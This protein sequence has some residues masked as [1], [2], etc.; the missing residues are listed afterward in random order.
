[1]KNAGEA[2]A[3]STKEAEDSARIAT[4]CLSSDSDSRFRSKRANVTLT[5]SD[6]FRK[7]DLVFKVYI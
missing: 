5:A 1:M 7:A 3:L 4:L 2:S 6:S